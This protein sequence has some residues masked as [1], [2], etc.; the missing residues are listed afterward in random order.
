MTAVLVAAPLWLACGLLILRERSLYARQSRLARALERW[1]L[2]RSPPILVAAP[3]VNDYLAA[4]VLGGM[5]V[6]V[7]GVS[8][9]GPS[10]AEKSKA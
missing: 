10:L 2:R 1:V 3:L 8:A 7:V 4:G 9:V 6:Q 5:A